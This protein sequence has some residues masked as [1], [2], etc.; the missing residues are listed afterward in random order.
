M[1]LSEVWFHDRHLCRSWSNGVGRATNDSLV[2][3]VGY[4]EAC[5]ERERYNFNLCCGEWL[6]LQ[7]AVSLIQ[8]CIRL[9]VKFHRM[10]P[11]SKVS[12]TP[13]YMVSEEPKDGDR[14]A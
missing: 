4:F 2:G 14:V 9:L 10:M 12:N 7:V 13:T 1:R 8:Y 11:V 5:V 3:A 6:L